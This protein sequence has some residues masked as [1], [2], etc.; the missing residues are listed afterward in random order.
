MV[1]SVFDR[2]APTY[3]ADLA[4]YKGGRPVYASIAH[5]K[6]EWYEKT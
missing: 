3:P 1:E 4:F 5:E 6:D 2:L